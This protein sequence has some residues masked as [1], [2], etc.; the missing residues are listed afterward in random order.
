MTNTEKQEFT[1]IIIKRAEAGKHIKFEYLRSWQEYKTN[2]ICRQATKLLISSLQHSADSMF[3][4]YC[5]NISSGTAD[6]T[7]L[8]TRVALMRMVAFY[9]LELSTI[10]DMLDEYEAYLFDGKFLEQFLFYEIRPISEC[11]DRRN[12]DNG[13]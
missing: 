3:K 8:L 1:K 6:V 7:L 12:M 13:F 2:R 9:R 11:W 10:E 4:Q 5:R